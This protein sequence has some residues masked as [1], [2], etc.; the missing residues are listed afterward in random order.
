MALTIKTV[1]CGREE[2]PLVSKAGFGL[3]RKTSVSAKSTKLGSI[4][5][6]W[7]GMRAGGPQKVWTPKF[8]RSRCFELA[9]G[10]QQEN[11]RNTN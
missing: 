9:P 10:A 2:L 8:A 6:L 7:K 11:L 3:L 4:D 1:S 5:F